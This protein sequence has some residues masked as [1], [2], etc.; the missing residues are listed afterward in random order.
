MTTE[1]PL[2]VA[3]QLKGVSRRFGEQTAVDNLSLEICKGTGFG[4][5]GPNGAGKTTTLKM[6]MGLI[7]RDG[8]QVRVLD[9]DPAV[10]DLAVKQRVGYVPEQQFIHRW[11]RVRQ[12]IRFCRTF[13][14]TWNDELCARLLRQFELD[15]RKRV[16][17]LSKGMVVKLALLLAMSHE[18]ELLI[19]DEPMAGLD[20]MIREEILDGILQTICDRRQT[21]LFSSHTLSDVQRMAE[22][23]GIIHQGR[24][25]IH[26]G[27]DE[28]LRRTKR[29]R[30]VLT[31][32]GAPAHPPE[33]TVWQRV[34]DREWLITVGD[35]SEETVTALRAQNPLSQVE[36]IDL[37]LEDIFKD[38][39]RGWRT[40]A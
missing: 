8:G 29:I 24:L 32:G 17:Q 12:V 13:Y 16:K 10:N 19:L 5:L 27:V 25:M 3:V 18:P 33:G 1:S 28:L 30:A 34:Q 14:V 37:G 36:V 9:L 4:L 6:V 11:M 26:C 20:P 23:V 15:E 22:A 2:D 40:S 39:L 7:R 21:V 38:Y 35:F 31:D